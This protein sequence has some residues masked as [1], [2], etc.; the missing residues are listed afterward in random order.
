MTDT[1]PTQ[2]RLLG[3]LLALLLLAQIDQPYPEVALLQHIP[4]M[5]LIVAA[6]WL[7]RRWPLSTAS[8]AC[9]A[10]FLPLPTLGG[11]YASSTSAERGVG[12]G[13]VRMCRCRW[14][15]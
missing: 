15:A 14:W 11:P 6:P 12:T 2:R 9:L 1:P 7:L 4:T 8:V 3:L 5:L 10:L 13:C